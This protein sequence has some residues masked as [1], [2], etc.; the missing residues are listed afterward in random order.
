[1]YKIH[2]AAK[3]LYSVSS[4]RLIYYVEIHK[5]AERGRARE[6]VG[7]SGRGEKKPNEIDQDK[8]ILWNLR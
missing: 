1:M 5:S 3:S 4:D 7:L 6:G 8:D 2:H